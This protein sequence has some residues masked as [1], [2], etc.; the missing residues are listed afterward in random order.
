[1]YGVGQSL[2]I[3]TYA[4]RDL[5]IVYNSLPEKLQAR[6]RE[7]MPTRLMPTGARSGQIRP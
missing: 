2:S 5:V 4:W 7:L 1:M 6:W 3:E